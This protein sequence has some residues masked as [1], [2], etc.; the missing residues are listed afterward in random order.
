MR[1]LTHL[2][3]FVT[4]PTFFIMHPSQHSYFMYYIPYVTYTFV[5][6]AET[7]TTENCKEKEF[8]AFSLKQH[9]MKVLVGKAKS[10]HFRYATKK[11]FTCSQ[12][13]IRF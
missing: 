8:A 3:Y 9:N 2:C 12:A 7:D 11:H 5:N 13:K 6:S 4:R 1:A 10:F